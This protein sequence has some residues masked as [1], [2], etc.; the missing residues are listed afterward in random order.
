M[1]K[2][3]VLVGLLLLFGSNS[4]SQDVAKSLDSSSLPK[5]LTCF[6]HY[7]V[8]GNEGFFENVNLVGGGSELAQNNF[9]GGFSADLSQWLQYSDKPSEL[10]F[11]SLV[12]DDE[13]RVNPVFDV[14]LYYWYNSQTKNL[15]MVG[16]TL[17]LAKKDKSR[18]TARQRL[19][20]FDKNYD[21][22]FKQEFS[23]EKGTMS[24]IEMP[25]PHEGSKVT[26][27]M[28]ECCLK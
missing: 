1:L 12:G 19:D 5:T 10:Q 20:R 13:S 6:V 8:K 4:Y 17:R 22:S 21:L 28:T 9:F 7:Q 26:Y 11:F 16:V 14:S 3:I 2:S 27:I 23:A 18:M 25:N 24:K 15:S